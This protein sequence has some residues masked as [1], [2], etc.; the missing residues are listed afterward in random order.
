[1]S[2]LEKC[3]FLI[4][5]E[6]SVGTPEQVIE[7]LGLIIDSKSLSL[8]LRPEK[9]VEIIDLCGKAL[10][11]VSVS[12]RDI[13]KIL[14]NLAWAIKAIPFAQS[15]Y[16]DLQAQYIES[17]KQL[18]GSLN[19]T[20]ILDKKSKQNLTWWIA[21]VRE[22]NGRPMS[23]TDPNLKIFLDASLSGWGAVLNEVSSRGPWTLGDKDRH[24]NKLELLAALNGLKYFTSQVSNLSVRLMLDNFTAV[25]YIIKSGGTRSPA[26]S[27]ISADI[28]DWCE[29][30]KLSNEAIQLIHLPGVLNV[31]ADQ[32]SRMRNESSDWKLQESTFQRIRALWEPEIDLF[33]ST[34]NRQLDRF[35]SWK[36]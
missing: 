22:S 1:V 20:I 30:R 32:Q 12:L 18:G 11:R 34:W 8:S 27:A 28:V 21:N 16:R 6:K 31:L 15:H 9:I 2:I 7:Y 13:A 29:K 36:P 24:I 26:L 5:L 25:H 35:V 17:C 19:S 3:G 14:G 33:A 10:E 23:A 4:N